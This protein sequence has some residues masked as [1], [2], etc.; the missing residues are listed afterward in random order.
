M[1][2][3]QSRVLFFVVAAMLSRVRECSQPNIRQNE[4]THFWVRSVIISKLE[5]AQ[6][7]ML[8]FAVVVTFIK[9]AEAVNRLDLVPRVSHHLQAVARELDEP[10][11]TQVKADARAVSLLAF[12]VEPR[13]PVVPHVS[14]RFEDPLCRDANA[15]CVLV[16][17]S[18]GPTFGFA[19]SHA[20]SGRV[21][22]PRC[23]VSGV[24]TVMTRQVEEE[25]GKLIQWTTIFVTNKASRKP[26]LIISSNVGKREIPD[27]ARMFF[28][29][30]GP[31]SWSS[32]G[33]K[34]LIGNSEAQEISAIDSK[35][36]MYSI[37]L[38]FQ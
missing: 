14:R 6:S 28:K 10:L 12:V 18:I 33:E 21:F 13:G 15:S 11:Q 3:A 24:W 19:N 32:Q 38:N 5:P 29:I 9:A 26:G 23:S 4:R 25:Q 27:F 2:P 8:F 37:A 16:F 20:F 31:G 36:H 7:R 22:P 35:Q 34:F 1:E 17:I 30:L